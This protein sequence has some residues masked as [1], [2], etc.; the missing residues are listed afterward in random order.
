MYTLYGALASPYSMKMRSLLRYRR[1]P[2]LWKDGEAVAGAL[3]K[4]RAPVI[5]VLEFPNGHFAN[6]STPLIYELEG[7]HEGR[8]VIPSDPAIAFVAHLIEDFADEW[9]TKAMFG[10]RWLDDLDQLQMSRWLA[11]DR[12]HGGGL[13]KSQA[14][15]EIFRERQV[16]RMA[17]VGCT[18]E[19]F[20]LIEASTRVVLGALEGHVTDR[21]FLFGSRPSIAEFGL[22]G[23]LSQ[24]ATDPT[25]QAMMRSDYPYTYRWLP[26]LDDMSGVEGEWIDEPSPAAL[27]IL[28]VAGEVYAPFLAAN[29]A[30]FKA[31]EEEF[32]FSAMGHDYAQGTFKYQVKCLADLRSR[33]GALNANDRER[34]ST[35]IGDGWIGLLGNQS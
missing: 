28:R 7:L 1:I 25:P 17:I 18:R 35:W 2:F 24:L 23:Q 3:A 10:Y 16:S 32:S 15:A 22:L 33:Y 29:A 14:D 8:G 13:D 34:I 26:H 21:F 5:P 31:G 11:F 20:P 19:N 6:D 9:L 4:V 30:A 27:D 12:M